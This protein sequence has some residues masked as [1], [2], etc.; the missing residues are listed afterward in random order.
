MF[1]YNNNNGWAVYLTHGLFRYVC[2]NFAANAELNKVVEQ[3]FSLVEL[4][5]HVRLLELV[6]SLRLLRQV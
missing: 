5:T 4:I 3:A 2:G 6:I 1:G